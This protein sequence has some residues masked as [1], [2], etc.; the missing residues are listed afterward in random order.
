MQLC[1]D[2]TSLGIIHKSCQMHD[3]LKILINIMQK[4]PMQQ[5]ISR[6]PVPIV[7]TEKGNLK[8]A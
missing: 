2:E 7:P 4:Y 8:Y 3:E 6:M 5:G 1:V